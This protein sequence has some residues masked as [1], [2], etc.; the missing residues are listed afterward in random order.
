MPKLSPLRK[1]RFPFYSHAGEEGDSTE[2]VPDETKPF[3][4]SGLESPSPT[5]ES[6]GART[7]E[8]DRALQGTVPTRSVGYLIALSVSITGYVDIYQNKLYPRKRN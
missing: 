7:D 8:N 3:L 6:F 1:S 5:E 2:G 4:A